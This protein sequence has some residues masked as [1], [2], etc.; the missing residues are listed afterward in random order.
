MSSSSS[1]S[2][3]SSNNSNNSNNLNNEPLQ[4]KIMAQERTFSFTVPSGGRTTLGT[5]IQLLKL[6][7]LKQISENKRI[8]LIALGKLLSDESATLQSLGIT[9][10]TFI[11]V[12]LTELPASSSTSSTSSSA[13]SNSQRASSSLLA[14]SSIGNNNPNQTSD[15]YRI[16]INSTDSNTN[17]NYLMGF[18]RLQLIGLD[19]DDIAVLRSQFLSNVTRETLPQV[20]RLPDETEA[21]RLLRAEELWMRSQPEHSEFAANIRP[22]LLSRRGLLNNSSLLLSNNNMGVNRT[23]ADYYEEAILHSRFR[24]AQSEPDGDNDG[25]NGNSDTTTGNRWFSSS[26]EG[27]NSAFLFGF[28][29]AWILGIIMLLFA[30]NPQASRKFKLGIMFG[31]GAHIATNIYLSLYGDT[32]NNSSDNSG[33]NSNTNRPLPPT[34]AA[35]WSGTNTGLNPIDLNN[36]G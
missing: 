27:S 2:G 31:V 33:G 32:T 17:N 29:F 28:F 8:R 14:S 1:S 35:A 34:D 19:T 20:Q 5:L 6:S 23:P 13:I 4:L 10:G 18:D 25:E 36:L 24:N 15:I 9:N 26:I 16:P 7:E 22:V 3:S 21:H 30:I 11:H 12:P